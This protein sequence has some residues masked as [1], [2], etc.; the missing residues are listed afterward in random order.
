MKPWN[1][2]T[3]CCLT[4][5]LVYLLWLNFAS[6]CPSTI[7][8]KIR[9]LDNL[10]WKGQDVGKQSWAWMGSWKRK[11]NQRCQ[12]SKVKVNLYKHQ[13]KL[14]FSFLLSSASWSPWSRKWFT[15]PMPLLKPEELN[16]WGSL[17]N[18]AS[19][20]L[21]MSCSLFSPLLALQPLDIQ[22]QF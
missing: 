8:W 10:Y 9:W 12:I 18:G 15:I 21:R 5:I 1:L 19:C 6:A 14:L 2:G 17:K 4:I 7:I 11:E 3:M 13:K 22:A 16:L 20:K